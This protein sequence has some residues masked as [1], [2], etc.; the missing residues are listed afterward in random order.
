MHNHDLPSKRYSL[1]DE[2]RK[3]EKLTEGCSATTVKTNAKIRVVTIKK[4]LS[5][6]S[7]PDG[8]NQW[9]RNPDETNVAT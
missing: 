3:R 7:C 9:K 4:V 2:R 5:P 8:V 6:Q 1:I